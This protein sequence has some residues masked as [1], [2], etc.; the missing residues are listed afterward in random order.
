MVPSY[1]AEAVLL[2]ALSTAR[3]GYYMWIFQSS[4]VGNW[5][6]DID[7][8]WTVSAG[9]ALDEVAGVSLDISNNDF[10][11][12]FQSESESSESESSEVLYFQKKASDLSSDFQSSNFQF[13]V[14]LWI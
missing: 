1:D 5:C 8:E 10:L 9:E 6:L 12:A 7:G 2:S 14:I 13:Y 4:I 3:S 11:V